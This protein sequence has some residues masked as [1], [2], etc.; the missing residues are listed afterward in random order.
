MM[1][2][3]YIKRRTSMIEETIVERGVWSKKH[4]ERW[5]DAFVVGNGHVGGMLTMN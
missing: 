5:E 1:K 2:I 3:V 4:G